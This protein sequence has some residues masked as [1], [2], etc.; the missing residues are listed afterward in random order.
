LDLQ[1]LDVIGWDLAQVPEPASVVLIGM[2][3]VCVVLRRRR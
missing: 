1:S 3:G 2:G